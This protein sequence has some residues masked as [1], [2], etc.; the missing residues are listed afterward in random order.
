V[1]VASFVEQ[2]VA[3]QERIM[4]AARHADDLERIAREGANRHAAERAALREQL[5]AAQSDVRSAERELVSREQLH[6]S[7]LADAR[8]TTAVSDARQTK[9]IDQLTEDLEVERIACREDERAVARLTAINEG[10]QAE[11]ARLGADLAAHVERE[12]TRSPTKRTRAK[13]GA[14]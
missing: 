2:T 12:T 14:L 6:T 10:I 11:T 8:T 5:S 7:A 4:S 1:A 3:M 9:Q 13:A